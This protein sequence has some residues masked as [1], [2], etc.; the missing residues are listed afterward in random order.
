MAV[1]RTVCVPLFPSNWKDNATKLY[2]FLDNIFQPS[3]T[4]FGACVADDLFHSNPVQS[5]PVQRLLTA[6]RT[7]AMSI[8]PKARPESGMSTLSTSHHR[9]RASVQLSPV[10]LSHD[11]HLCQR[12][13]DHIYTICYFYPVT[14][15]TGLI[16]NNYYKCDTVPKLV[17]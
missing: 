9:P 4:L 15:A 10:I 7:R 17:T 12:M 11:H 8:L 5:S 1:P 3:P 14:R 13:H 16:A 6:E 2:L